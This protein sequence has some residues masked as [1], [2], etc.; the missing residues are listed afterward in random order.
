MKKNTISFPKNLLEPLKQ[1]LL[2]EK[3]RLILTKRRLDKEDP[4]VTG[5]REGGDSSLDD[6]VDEQLNHDQVYAEKREASR[7]LINIKKTLTRI[8]IGKYGMCENCGKMIDTDRL[9]VNPTAAYCLNCEKAKEK[10]K[11][12]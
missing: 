8:K 10:N 3:K 2:N 12:K 7:T 5:A 1:Y 6:E 4:Y 9:A 11:K